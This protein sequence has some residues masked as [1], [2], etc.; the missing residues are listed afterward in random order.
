MLGRSMF[1]GVGQ[2]DLGGMTAGP[3]RS[4]PGLFVAPQ[5]H[6]CVLCVMCVQN[7]H[8]KV[9]NPGHHKHMYI[10]Q[11]HLHVHITGVPKLE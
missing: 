3:L 8:M 5:A 4:L 2:T 1:F 9:C 7:E 10:S 11:T 6:V